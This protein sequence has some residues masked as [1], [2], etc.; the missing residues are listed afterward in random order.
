M[1]LVANDEL[2]PERL[3]SPSADW[4]TIQEFA[5]TFNGF[6]H[7][8]SFEKCAEIANQ[9]R[10]ST[11]TELRTCLFFEQRRWHHYGDEP[12]AEAMEYIRELI[13]KIGAKVN[14]GEHE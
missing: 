12:D 4:D 11:L 10:P 2:Q 7:W 3:P 13:D 5:L 9:M 8:G 14:S 6:K 1:E